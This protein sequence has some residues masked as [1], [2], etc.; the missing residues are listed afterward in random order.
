[1]LLIATEEPLPLEKVK[2]AV[3]PWVFFHDTLTLAQ[4]FSVALGGGGVVGWGVLVAVGASV[5]VAL[6]GGDVYVGVGL[7]TEVH[8]GVGEGPG[9][10]VLVVVGDGPAVG[11]PLLVADGT[12]VALAPG[13][14]GA[15][16]EKD[17]EPLDVAVSVPPPSAKVPKTVSVVV[18]LGL[19][20]SK[21]SPDVSVALSEVSVPATVVSR[22]SSP[23]GA[24]GLP[25]T[26]V[27]SA[28]MVPRRS[29]VADLPVIASRSGMRFK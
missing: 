26:C 24:S 2:R 4:T 13:A 12:G 22:A 21:P 27:Y 1:M 11:G 23:C 19:T 25:A 17:P 3:L 8:D 28:S 15:S 5:C 20:S 6:G 14:V 9:V 18:E 7:K 16:V 10:N 29:S